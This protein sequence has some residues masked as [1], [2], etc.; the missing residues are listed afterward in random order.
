VF[1]KPMM[2]R[3]KQ[4]V[5]S[6]ALVTAITSV[7]SH[8]LAAR[9]GIRTGIVRH[10]VIGEQQG[11]PFAFLAGSSL[12]FDGLAMDR[13]SRYFQQGMETWFVA[14]SSPPEWEPFQC[15]AR[16]ARLTLFAISAYDLNENYLCDFRSQVVSFPQTIRDLAESRASWPVAKR[17]LSQYPLKCVR[18]LFP[19]A[20]RSQGVMGG[21]KEKLRNL[22]RP[23]LRIESEV[24]PAVP[25]MDGD[26][27]TPDR[28]QRVSD[29]SPNTLL[30]QLTKMR[31]ACHGKHS[32]AGLKRLA[33]TRMLELAQRQGKAI[34]VVLP[35]SPAY[36]KELL[37]QE[38][39]RQFEA[40][41]AAH[42]QA[43]PEILW[44]RLD[45][46]PELNSDTN[47]SDVVHMNVFGQGI[48]T[49]A[50]LSEC[51][52]NAQRLALSR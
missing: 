31:T 43:A 47:F 46:V 15:R 4:L 32:Y 11:K 52:R 22:L 51:S 3:W 12:L 38:T 48:A 39:K 8:Q 2:K 7:L 26:E 9:L 40:S 27:V 29:S 1:V 25:Q 23:W 18:M 14:G 6:V 20:G 17:V 10:R 45:Q 34:V 19:T 13:V 42:Q 44:V 50:L 37:D 30:R 21:F 49:D 28:L 35:V 16:D 36:Q 24:G 33:L 41:L 5:L